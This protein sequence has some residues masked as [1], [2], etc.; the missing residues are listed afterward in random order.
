MIYPPRQLP[1]LSLTITC[2]F[3]W[4]SR[5]GLM[6]NY[7][8]ITPYRSG[9]AFC[10]LSFRSCNA[11]LHP[12]DQHQGVLDFLPP[13]YYYPRHSNDVLSTWRERRE[14]WNNTMSRRPHPCH[15]HNW[16][17][18]RKYT[19]YSY[20]DLATEPFLDSI[21]LQNCE[22]VFGEEEGL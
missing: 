4:I 21:N 19:A 22:S 14:W 12:S 8:I 18:L 3:F 10:L 1:R 11:P 9:C 15:I 13:P 17:S 20:D 2:K 16:Y 5:L 7:T 6:D